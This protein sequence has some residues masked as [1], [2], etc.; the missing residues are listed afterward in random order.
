[1]R[2]ISKAECVPLFERVRESSPGLSPENLEK[3]ILNNYPEN[4]R[5]RDG[6]MQKVFVTTL[7]AYISQ[8]RAVHEL[9]RNKN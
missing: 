2:K 7:N 6:D 8:Y 1:M 5:S 3:V 4:A 9:R